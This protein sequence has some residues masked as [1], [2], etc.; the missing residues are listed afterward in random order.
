M[1]LTMSYLWFADSF[2]D[3]AERKDYGRGCHL[4]W[5]P[6]PFLPPSKIGSGNQPFQ[7]FHLQCPVEVKLAGDGAPMHRST[8]NILL[9]FSLPSLDPAA[10]SST[11]KWLNIIYK[12][13]ATFN[14]YAYICSFRR[15]RKLQS[16]EGVVCPSDSRYQPLDQNTRGDTEWLHPSGTWYSFGWRFIVLVD[17]VGSQCSSHQLFMYLLPYK[18]RSTVC[19]Y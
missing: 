7:N 14:R 8:S 11:G 12:I 4:K 17:N 2:L 10:T 6:H 13:L 3:H 15:G 19:C 18:E 5:Q 16:H 1:S 9:S